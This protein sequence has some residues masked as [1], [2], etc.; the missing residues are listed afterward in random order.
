LR[1]HQF[2]DLGEELIDLEF[3][4]SKRIG[5]CEP[6]YRTSIGRF[7]YYVFLEFRE[8]LKA[9]LPRDLRLYLSEESKLNHHC[10]LKETLKELS[11][12]LKDK[13]IRKAYES[14]KSL[15]EARNDSDYN[16]TTFI[17]RDRVVDAEVDLERIDKVIKRIPH[18]NRNDL[19]IAF[20]KALNS[21]IIKSSP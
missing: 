2:K 14:L 1:P 3:S 4:L 16:V 18:I 10:I 7:Y 5:S 12:I 6:I 20:Q 9:N 13:E 11:F 17:S 19:A 21:C 15:R 8:T